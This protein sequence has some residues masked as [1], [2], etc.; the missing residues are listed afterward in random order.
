ML[1]LKVRRI[2]KKSQVKELMLSLKKIRKKKK[3]KKS[4]ILL[5]QST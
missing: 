3:R 4:T 1:T 2:K 5:I